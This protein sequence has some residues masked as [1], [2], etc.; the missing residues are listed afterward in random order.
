MNFLKDYNKPKVPVFTNKF[1]VPAL[2]QA[3]VTDKYQDAIDKVTQ[4]YSNSKSE[5]DKVTLKNLISSIKG[6][7]EE[8]SDG[9]VTSEEATRTL[10]VLIAKHVG[11]R[12]KTHRRLNRKKT[13][14][15]RK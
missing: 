8:E 13:R 6:L 14:R 1:T 10:S 4:R 9:E 12:R 3:P 5:S 11:G 15:S 2:A 7:K